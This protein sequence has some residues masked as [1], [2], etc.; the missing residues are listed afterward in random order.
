[1]TKRNILVAILWMSGALLSFSAT[2]VATRALAPTFS[3][4]EILAFRNAAAVV[5]LVAA[6]LVRPALRPALRPRRLRLHLAR[7]AA[8]WGGTFGWTLGVTLLP[9]ATVFALEFTAP[10]WVALLAVLFLREDLTVGRIVAV[11]FG[12]LGVLVILRPGAVS[13]DARSLIVLAAAV[14]FA[15][16]AIATKALTRTESVFAILFFMNLMQFVP[17]FAGAGRGFWLKLEPVH[18]APLAAICLGGLFSHLCLTN[19][20][21]Y[22]DATMVMPLDFLRV[23][24]IALVA[25][26]LYGEPLDPFVLLGS[27]IIV[28]GIVF[29]LRSE[30]RT[31]A[32]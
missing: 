5:I 26:R 11:A 29:N 25:W 30:A 27:A 8:H 7:N 9:L 13:L 20:Y 2:A 10:A 6:A 18:A 22:G 32:A 23:P 19:A 12:F 31:A 21:R 28:V 14:G 1:V 4:F 16:T 24:L 17:N 15:V 3:V